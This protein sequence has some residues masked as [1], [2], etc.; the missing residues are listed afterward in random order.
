[1]TLI[2]IRQF[3][4][5]TT[6][7]LET[8]TTAD[9]LRHRDAIV[10]ELRGIHTRLNE[11]EKLRDECDI[12]VDIG[13]QRSARKAASCRMFNLRAIQTELDAR[14]TDAEAAE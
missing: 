3:G 10:A 9:L 7:D 8:T 14:E 12:P 2:T 4:V 13:W 5:D 1:M 6:L 11:A